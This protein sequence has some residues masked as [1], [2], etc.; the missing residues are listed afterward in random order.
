MNKT[1]KNRLITMLNARQFAQENMSSNPMFYHT[2]QHVE[3]MLDD[4]DELNKEL[5]LS[6]EEYY[7]LYIAICY[8]DIVYDPY[9]CTN[10]KDSANLFHERYLMYNNATF[11]KKVE[12]LIMSTQVI[13]GIDLNTHTDDKL[14]K[15]IHTL[16]WNIFVDYD[17]CV[18]SRKKVF[19]EACAKR[20]EPITIL[21]NQIN[22]YYS[23]INSMKNKNYKIDYFHEENN[24]KAL[25]TLETLVKQRT[26]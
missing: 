11:T 4:L 16:D 1:A 9:S 24:K 5:K 12:K 26:F 25:N 15:V 14:E 17:A 23:I 21:E 2:F 7:T 10:E 6:E 18:E 3:K 13:F 22:F 20:F 19:F 8:H